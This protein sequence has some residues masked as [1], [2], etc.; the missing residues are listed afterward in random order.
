M[1]NEQNK[2]LEEPKV[3]DASSIV[4]FLNEAKAKL[5]I[6]DGTII[7]KTRKRSFVKGLETLA[8]TYKPLIEISPH[9]CS[10]GKSCSIYKHYFLNVHINPQ[11]HAEA[12]HA[13]YELLD[14]YKKR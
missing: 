7:F 1:P 4:K 5:Q 6:C 8:K 12:A 11:K 10:E 2:K 13:L 3:A 9:E 14:K